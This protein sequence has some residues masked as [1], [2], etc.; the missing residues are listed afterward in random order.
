M[1]TPAYWYCMHLYSWKV[2]L[3]PLGLSGRAV[4]N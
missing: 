3:D 4:S 2:L 1:F